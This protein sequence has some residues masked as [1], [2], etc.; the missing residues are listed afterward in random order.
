M[1]FFPTTKTDFIACFLDF[2]PSRIRYRFNAIKIYAY[3]QN[4]TFVKIAY[5]KSGYH[6]SSRPSFLLL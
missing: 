5:E 6:W 1:G 4:L 3:D 2:M